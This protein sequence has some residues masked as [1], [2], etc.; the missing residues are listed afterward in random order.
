MKSKCIIRNL[1]AASLFLA[2]CA[3]GPSSYIN[4]DVD[5]S[6]I[7]RVAVFPFDNLSSDNQAAAKVESVFLAELLKVEGL[8]V[9]AP[10]ETRAI[11]AAARVPFSSELSADQIVALGQ[12]LGVEAVFFGRVEDYG[13][14]SDSSDRSN[15]LTATFSLAETVTGTTIWHVQVNRDG[16][17]VWRKIFGGGSASFYD[18]T[19]GAVR[20][21]MGTLF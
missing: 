15:A 5:F 9:V 19:R 11:V 10:G 4:E 13:V 21:A 2:G 14:R 8:R 16:G 18:V 6:Y 12:A 7:Q 20:E 3:A 17:S 1:L